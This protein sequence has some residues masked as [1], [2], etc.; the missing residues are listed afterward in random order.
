MQEKTKIKCIISGFEDLVDEKWRSK[1]T[2]WP[3]LKQ[4]FNQ[5]HSVKHSLISYFSDIKSICDDLLLQQQWQRMSR[6]NALEM[7]KNP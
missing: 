7:H 6:S 3:D 4:C 1:E 2:T 5:Y